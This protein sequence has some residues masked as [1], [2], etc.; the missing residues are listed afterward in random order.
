[1]INNKVAQKIKDDNPWY[2]RPQ[3]KD[4]LYYRTIEQRWKFFSKFYMLWLK[5]NP[6]G[7]ADILD[8]GCG[9]GINLEFFKTIKG[10]NIEAY[11]YNPIRVER[12]REKYPDIK[13]SLVDLTDIKD[14]NKKFDIILCSQVLEHIENDKLALAELKSILKP[15]GILIVG[16]PNEG[17][18]LAQL[19][20]NTLEPNIGKTT[21]H[22]QFYTKSGLLKLFTDV[23]LKVLKLCRENFFFPKLAINSYMGQCDW[24]FL[25]M[26]ILKIFIPSQAAGLYF[27][28][29]KSEDN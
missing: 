10:A 11:E 6:Q 23:E 17:C 25:V 8:A 26:K 27:A 12:A 13:I 18:F 19:R 7:S 14:K 21:D 20:N 1:M 16:V 28:L 2:T 4:S 9:D 22:V 24:G 29:K 3:I 5:D 15:N